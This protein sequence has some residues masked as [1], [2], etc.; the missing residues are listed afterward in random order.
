R[1][2]RKVIDQADENASF[3][4]KS[5]GSQQ[6]RLTKY[7][8]VREVLAHNTVVD[9]HYDEQERVFLVERISAEEDAKASWARFHYNDAIENNLVVAEV[10]DSNRLSLFFEPDASSN[11]TA[12]YVLS[13]VESSGNA[14][15]SY[16][17]NDSEKLIMKAVIG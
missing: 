9:Y 17:F 1:V 12:K 6:A 13:H 3:V 10:S 5:P 14:D 2:Y 11:D 16:D 7:Q 8:L 15:F 4:S